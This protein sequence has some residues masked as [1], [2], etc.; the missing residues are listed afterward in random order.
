M[1]N[2]L[3]L[4][5]TDNIGDVILTLPL[6]I[7][8]K[9]KYPESKILFL[10][11]EYTR[12]VIEACSAVDEFISADQ[13]LG[14]GSYEKKI[15]LIKN[16]H[17]DAIIHVFPGRILAK[18]AKDARIPLRIGTFNRIFHWFTC[19]KLIKLSRKNSRYHE[20]E[21]NFKLIEFL[22]EDDP[23]IPS[24]EEL[25]KTIILDK[26]CPIRSD[27]TSLL[28]PK[29]INLILHPKSRGSAREWGLENFNQLIKNLSPEQ[30]K[31]FITGTREEGI[32]C[33]NLLQENPSIHDMTG[34]LNL[35]ELISFISHCD[36]LVA[37]STGPLHIAASTG[38]HAIGLFAPKH[39]IH[40]G[41]WGA[42]GPKSQYLVVDKFCNSGCTK[43]TKCSCIQEIQPDSVL[44]I[45]KKI[46]K[47]T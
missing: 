15:Q 4:S 33:K 38:I 47:K 37:A 45:L 12:A 3:L 2:R 19:N 28:D 40:P 20:T 6:S 1:I 9:K 13:V 36:V 16:I 41:R 23:K 14:E 44:Q 42:L 32:L 11:K 24:L 5:R 7:W 22:L 29:K 43:N 26:I 27:L 25:S 31:V 10:G 39:S 30:F 34:K 21:L 46:R 35:A 18:L 17:A 8:W